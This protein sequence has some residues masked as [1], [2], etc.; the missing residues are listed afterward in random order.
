MNSH[1]NFQKSV[2]FP[3]GNKFI[4]SPS[5]IRPAWLE[6]YLK[7]IQ[8][9]PLFFERG[10]IISKIVKSTNIHYIC[11]W[12]SLTCSLTKLNMISVCTNVYYKLNIRTCFTGHNFLKFCLSACLSAQKSACPWLSDRQFVESCWLH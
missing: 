11:Y 7:I 6:N 4:F 1:G 12:L 9:I 8:S 2:Q 5:P 10:C 3:G